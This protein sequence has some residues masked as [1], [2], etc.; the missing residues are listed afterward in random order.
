MKLISTALAAIL[1]LAVAAPALAQ[2]GVP[3]ART[4][5]GG[6]EERSYKILATSKT[7]T[8][9]K[10]MQEAGDAGYRFVAVMGG[11]TA[12]GGKEVVVLVEKSP[13]DKNTYSYR[14][15]ATSKTSTLQKELQEASDA[16]YHAVGQTVFESM[17]GGKETVAIVQRSSGA[18]GAARYEYKLVATTKTSTLEKELKELADEGFQAIDLTVGKTAMGGSEIVV[19]TRRAK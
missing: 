7:S 18:A 13:D 4:L 12:V 19:I 14:L 8:M 2:P 9:Q 1:C 5:R 6:V 10:E 11:E 15:L 16:G 3:A 17:F